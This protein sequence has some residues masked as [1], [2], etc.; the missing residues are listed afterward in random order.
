[1]EG[2]SVVWRTQRVKFE[3]PVT[4]KARRRV[5]NLLMDGEFPVEQ[6]TAKFFFGEIARES[7]DQ[8]QIALAFV[9]RF[10]CFAFGKA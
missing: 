4:R 9:L 1:M 7:P 3:A 5:E 8:H 6:R 10:A 2:F